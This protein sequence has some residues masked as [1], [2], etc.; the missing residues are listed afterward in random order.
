MRSRSNTLLEIASLTPNPLC[1]PTVAAAIV[2][3]P[4]MLRTR[5][6]FPVFLPV[7]WPRNGWNSRLISGTH[8][9]PLDLGNRLVRQLERAETNAHASPIVGLLQLSERV[10]RIAHTTEPAGG[11]ASDS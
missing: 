10:L 11:Q 9:P 3:M 4:V 2:P 7:T 5:K 1:T 8:G 6:R